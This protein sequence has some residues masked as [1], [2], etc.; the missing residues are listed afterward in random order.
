VA[1]AG[2]PN[3]AVRYEVEPDIAELVHAQLN[4]PARQSGVK[5]VVVM[6]SR[7]VRR[8][9]MEARVEGHRILCD[10]PP[11]GGGS[12]VAP[13][14]LRYFV[15][16]ILQCVQIWI[17]KVA[18]VEK[19]AICQLTAA[20]EAYL[21]RGTVGLDALTAA[22]DTASGRGFERILLHLDVDTNDATTG[23]EMA[24]IVRK[25]VRACPA[26]VSFARSATLELQLRHNGR[27]LPV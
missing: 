1:D 7:A 8:Y 5:P 15:A 10:E 12:D 6:Q 24:A 16:G 25:G 4:D 19:V 23:E 11:H 27:R 17:V 21:E 14:P 18:A 26:A 9:Q 2:S 3:Q 13:A 20:A 22:E